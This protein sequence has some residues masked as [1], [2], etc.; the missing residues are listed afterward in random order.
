MRL[1]KTEKW[2]PPLSLRIPSCSSKFYFF[3]WKVKPSQ[4]FYTCRLI[5]CCHAA[6]YLKEN[7]HLPVFRNL[8]TGEPQSSLP[9]SQSPGLKA[10]TLS[11]SRSCYSELITEHLPSIFHPC[12][13]SINLPSCRLGSCSRESCRENWQETC[14]GTGVQRNARELLESK[15]KCET[16][17]TRWIHD[18]IKISFQLFY[19]IT[20]S[21]VR[22]LCCYCTTLLDID[23][24]WLIR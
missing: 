23:Q 8:K 10:Q 22:T 3:Q 9:S 12:E 19:G 21:S 2:G 6:D 13:A 24:F 5:L 15:Q 18:R 1:L 11:S 16:L 17:S 7:Y 14:D 4:F 20:S